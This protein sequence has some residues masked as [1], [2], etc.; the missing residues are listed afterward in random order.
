MGIQ[1]GD[2][3]APDMLG[4]EET[5]PDQARPL[6]GPEDPHRDWEGGSIIF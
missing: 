3:L 4:P 6:S 2:D 1:E 5:R